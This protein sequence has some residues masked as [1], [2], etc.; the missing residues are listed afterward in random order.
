M[1]AHT[2]IPA[3]VL[4]S[5]G[6]RFAFAGEPP[7]IACESLAIPAGLTLLHGDTGS[8][9]TTLLRV[10]AGRQPA[11]GRLLLDGID[12]ARTPDAYRRA[13]FHVD[14]RDADLDALTPRACTA[15]WREDD[16]GF[17]AP[18]WSSMVEGFALGEHL[19]KRMEMLSTGSRRKVV[20]AAA[21]AS[22][23]ALVLLDEPTAALDKASVRWLWEALA[24]HARP[25]RPQAIVLASS[26]PVDGLPLAATFTLPLR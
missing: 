9:K 22:G 21:L 10:L 4:Q 19:D 15:T 6:L 18:R 3:P 11:Q 1:T 14:A 12:L 8:G 16:P 24:E 25:G 17:D 5:Q 20:L 26:L 13:V 23:R 7:L 2:P